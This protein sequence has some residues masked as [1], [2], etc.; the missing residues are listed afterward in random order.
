VPS[1]ALGF[2]NICVRGSICN[3][4][5][6]LQ[7]Q[8]YKSFL[9][10]KDQLKSF[11]HHEDFLIFLLNIDLSS[12]NWKKHLET[13]GPNLTLALILHYINYFFER[14]LFLLA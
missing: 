1:G 12:L 3:I 5:I 11:A 9:I 2:W 4:G 14:Q 6:I 7:N 8:L 13:K 10:F